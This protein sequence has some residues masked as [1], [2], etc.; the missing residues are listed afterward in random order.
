MKSFIR[1]GKRFPIPSTVQIRH[2]LREFCAEETVRKVCAKAE[3]LSD[4]A[5][6]DEIYAHR[7]LPAAT[8]LAAN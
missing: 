7:A 4:N 5:P 1:F 2:E 8:S 6:W 3:G